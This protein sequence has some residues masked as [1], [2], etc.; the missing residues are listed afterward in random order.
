MDFD[1]YLVFADDARNY[2]K[3]IVNQVAVIRIEGEEKFL[4]L[5]RKFRPPGLEECLSPPTPSAPTPNVR[6]SVESLNQSITSSR[7]PPPYRAPPPPSVTPTKSNPSS[8]L[9]SSPTTSPSTPTNKLPDEPPLAPAR[10]RNSLDKAKKELNVDMVPQQGKSETLENES[11]GERKISVKERMQKFNRMASESDLLK[12]PV[13]NNP[14][15]KIDKVSLG[16]IY[17]FDNRGQFIN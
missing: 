7:Q 9:N 16:S 4:V 2:F 1:W 11:E 10:K 15:K 3:E 17:I 5:K 13:S 8:P 12:V 6:S 14:K